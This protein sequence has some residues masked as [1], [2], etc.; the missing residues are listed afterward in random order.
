MDETRRHYIKWNISD[1]DGQILYDFT[2]IWD[3]RKLLISEKQRENWLPG[4]GRHGE[5]LVKVYKLTV[6]RWISSGYWTYSMATIVNNNVLNIW[7][8]L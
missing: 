6:I 5:M 8:M 4:G 2:Y 1:T 3:L 7:N